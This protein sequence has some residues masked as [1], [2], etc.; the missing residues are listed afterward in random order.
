MKEP[1]KIAL[2]VLAFLIVGMSVSPAY[3]RTWQNVPEKRV[4]MPPCD[5]VVVTNPDGSVT[6][7]YIPAP[8]G[9]Y[10]PSP[11]PEYRPDK[12]TTDPLLSSVTAGPL[13]LQSAQTSAASLRPLS[14]PTKAAEP[15]TDAGQ[16]PYTS[17]ITPTGGRTYTV[18]INTVPDAKLVPNLALTYNSQAG[19]GVAG[20]GWSLSGLSSISLADKN[21]YYDTVV[22][23]P[24]LDSS[25]PVFALDGVRIV[26]TSVAALAADY[27]YETATGHI[28]VT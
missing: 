17:D 26:K 8:V 23:S 27:P 13:A 3:A 20:F 28:L 21:L 15:N 24:S 18:P 1:L 5:S 12:F 16:I 11:A 2:Y 14:I 10:R 7:T 6:T 9:D 4:S 19:N 25:S 22:E